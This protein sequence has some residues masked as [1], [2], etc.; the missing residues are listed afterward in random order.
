L[1]PG[2]P[3]VP[4]APYGPMRALGAPCVDKVH[5]EVQGPRG[6]PESL[7][8]FGPIWA[9]VPIL[10]SFRAQGPRVPPGG[11]LGPHWA[12]WALPGPWFP[13]G[14][15]GSLGRG[16]TGLGYPGVPPTNRAPGPTQGPWVPG[17]HGPIWA[18]GAPGCPWGPMGPCGPWV[19]P[20]SY[21]APLGPGCPLG[22][23]GHFQVQGPR[24]SP[25]VPGPHWAHLGP[26]PNSY[27]F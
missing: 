5:S 14:P 18:Q 8:A 3:W 4:L 25:W 12:P 15:L 1:G 26:G 24:E 19:P 23:E 11:P 7:G 13:P 21:W 16:T 10:M 9:Q 2:S 22:S 6:P 17:S 27:E 20:G